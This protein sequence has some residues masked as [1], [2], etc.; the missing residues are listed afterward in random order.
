MKHGGKRSDPGIGKDTQVL[1]GYS[2][3]NGTKTD[4]C[5]TSPAGPNL[6]NVDFILVFPNDSA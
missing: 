2:R 4:F 5:S 6:E 3:E 1:A